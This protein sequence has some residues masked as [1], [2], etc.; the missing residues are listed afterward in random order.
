MDRKLDLE[1]YLAKYQSDEYR[2][3]PTP[4]DSTNRPQRP[5]NQG[6]NF[7]STAR[8]YDEPLDF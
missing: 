3:K 6:T 1:K 8:A 4:F 7:K 5:I 2:R